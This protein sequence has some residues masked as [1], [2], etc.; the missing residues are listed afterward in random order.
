[1]STKTRFPARS[2]TSEYSIILRRR[3]VR[4]H[5]T[6]T[7]HLP[8]PYPLAPHPLKPLTGVD[9]FRGRS[10]GP[11]WEWN[12]DPGNSKWSVKNQLR[13]KTATVTEN[14][15]RARNTL[16]HRILGPE[17][18]ATIE[19]DYSA[20]KDGDRA[21]L[22]LFRDSSAWIGIERD[23]G[24]FKVVMEENLTMDNR[25]QTTSTGTEVAGDPVSSGKIWLRTSADI[26]PGGRRTAEF[27]YSTDG[28]TVRPIGRPFVLNNHWQL[29]V[30]YRYAIFNYATQ[31]LGGEVS[32]S[33]FTMTT[34]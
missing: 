17:S 18:T 20:M 25:W 34:P 29:F 8:H 16:T 9:P 19:L 27:S 30:G 23:D 6:Y 24:S 22:A 7:R 12:H 33:S 14:L 3:G 5:Q 15:Y 31:S 11:E 10:L 4:S 2:G 26:H 13:L 32:V 21:G 28:R 1:M